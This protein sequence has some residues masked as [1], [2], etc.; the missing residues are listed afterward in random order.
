M[1]FRSVRQQQMMKQTMRF[2]YTILFFADTLLFLGLSFLFLRKC[3]NGTSTGTLVLIFSGIVI[4]IF[5]LTL[6]L[7]AYLTLP[8]D[9]R[10]Q[11]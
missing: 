6:L 4:S 11:R 5:L 9:K 7:R 10:R 3:D 8:P 1:Y 2:L